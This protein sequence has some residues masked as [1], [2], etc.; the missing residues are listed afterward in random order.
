MAYNYIVY[1]VYLICKSLL[2]SSKCTMPYWYCSVV[3]CSNYMNPIFAGL[4]KSKWEKTGRFPSGN[5]EYIDV[6]VNGNRY[7]VEVSLDRQFEI[8]RPTDQYASSL[9]VFPRIFVG[10]VEELKKIVKLM[11]SAIKE[12]MKGVDLHVPPWRRKGYMQ[13]KW[14]GN[15]KRTT[16][17]VPSKDAQYGEAVAGKRSVGFEAKP[18]I[19]YNCREDFASKVGLRVGHLTAVFNGNVNGMGLQL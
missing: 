9:N 14:F 1:Y 10:K 3:I 15:Y 2:F 8:A 11:C 5:Y 4:C 17:E 19:S 12:S 7:I 6:N 18:S 13:S 16:N